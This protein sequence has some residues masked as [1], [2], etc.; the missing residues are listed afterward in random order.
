MAQEQAIDVGRRDELVEL[1]HSSRRS[2][3]QEASHELAAMARQDAAT[4]VEVA[5]ALVQALELPEAQTRWECLDALS[6]IVQV[7]PQCALDAFEGAEDALFDEGS[8]AAHLSAFR[9]LSRYGALGEEESRRA[10][11]LMRE[12][13]QCYHGDPEYRE[14]LI[15]LL[16]FARGA[17]APE[18][19]EALVERMAFDAKSGRGF[20]RAY[21]TEICSMLGKA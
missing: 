3:R 13:L 18:V 5:P 7:S 16:D 15:C 1:L 14:M 12:A 17:I 11:P 10:W 21:S 9:F 8:A 6:Q 2:T 20:Y 4:M 19:G